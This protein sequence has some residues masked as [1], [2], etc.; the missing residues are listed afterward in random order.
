M[1]TAVKH[2]PQQAAGHKHALSSTGS[3]M[4]CPMASVGHAGR[5]NVVV[6]GALINQQRALPAPDC[7]TR[8][9]TLTAA[10]SNHYVAAQTVDASQSRRRQ[11]LSAE[12]LSPAPPQP[13]LMPALQADSAAGVLGQVQPSRA[14]RLGAVSRPEQAAGFEWAHDLQLGPGRALLASSFAATSSAAS[15]RSQLST[16]GVSQL[17]PYGVDPVYLSSSSFYDATMDDQIGDPPAWAVH[18]DGS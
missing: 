5:N 7:A 14:P 11:L 18:C 12:V 3:I 16:L 1:H 4:V 9:T 8:Y 2:L 6:G 15:N 17:A 13:G 10:C